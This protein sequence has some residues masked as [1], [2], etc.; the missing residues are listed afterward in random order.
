MLLGLEPLKEIL[1]NPT[2]RPMTVRVG[3]VRVL[4]EKVERLRAILNEVRYVDV[5]PAGG[6]GR[7]PHPQ[8]AESDQPR[9]SLRF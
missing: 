1:E 3:T 4:V 2:G 7:K 9:R 5:M 6:K 8:S